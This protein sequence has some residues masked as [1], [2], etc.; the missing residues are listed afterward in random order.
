[1][2]MVILKEDC[3]II[4]VSENGYGKR[5]DTSEYRQQARSGKG[6]KAGEFNEKTGLLVSMKAV[7]PTDD[8]MLIADNGIA[9][10]VKVSEISK[11]GRGTQGVRIMKFK[12]DA[13]LM[14]ITTCVSEEQEEK[15]AET[16]ETIDNDENVV[17]IEPDGETEPEI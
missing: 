7:Y 11:I 2:D 1:M 13:K 9:I 8:I 15:L 12:N 14:S 16:E 17:V 4:T 5:C 10:R 3:E 6:V